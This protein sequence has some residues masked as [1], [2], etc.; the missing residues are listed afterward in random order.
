MCVLQVKIREAYSM[1]LFFKGPLAV[2]MEYAAHGSLKNFLSKVKMYASNVFTMIEMEEHLL[3]K[4]PLG[5]F[6]PLIDNHQLW[7]FS[8]QVAKGL[9][10]LASRKVDSVFCPLSL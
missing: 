9:E 7:K 8:T 1:T 2:V 6:L 3:S 4:D 5:G 10:Y